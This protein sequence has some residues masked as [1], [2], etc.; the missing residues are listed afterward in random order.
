MKDKI[1]Y[2]I[3]TF[4]QVNNSYNIDNDDFGIGAYAL[5]KASKKAFLA[6]PFLKSMDIPMLVIGRVDGIVGGRA[7]QYPVLLKAGSDIVTCCSGSSLEVR[8]EFR[9]LNLALDIIMDPITNKRG[10]TLLYA[11]FSNDGL[12]VYKA[13]RFNMFSLRKWMQPNR[14]GFLMEMM[15]VHGFLS[16]V[17][18][19]LINPILSIMLKLT[20]L[21]F[22]NVDKSLKIEKVTKVPVWVD[23]IVLNDGHKYTEVHDHK[24]LQWNL[25]NMF[26]DER[27]NTNSFYIVSK[28]SEEIGFFMTKERRS[29]IQ[30]RNIDSILIGK[31]VEWGTKDEKLLS[32]LELYKLA[33]STFSKRVDIIEAYTNEQDTIRGLKRLLFFGHGKHYIAFKDLTK[34][35][36]DAKDPNL[37]RLRF[38]YS[39]SIMN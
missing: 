24:W 27:E 35:Y 34:K 3:I 10:E 14:I 2:E 36:K 12:N 28:N 13:L 38:G 33:F 11:D 29:S 19:I 16:K 30:S 8:K 23:D 32:E 9:H 4:K 31:I 20:K 22:G 21:V 7:M 39:D 1:T 18:S 37:W 25:D 17:T 5:G 26:H 15:G 6:N